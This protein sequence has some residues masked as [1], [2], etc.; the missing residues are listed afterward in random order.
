MTGN[1][2]CNVRQSRSMRPFACGATRV[3]ALFPSRTTRAAT[4]CA[5]HERLQAAP[6]RRACPC[7]SG[8]RK[9]WPSGRSIRKRAS[10]SALRCALAWRS[11]RRST[12]FRRGKART[13]L[14]LVPVDEASR[15]FLLV[16]LYKAADVLARVA[17]PQSD[18]RLLMLASKE[19]L[20]I[21][22]QMLPI[23]RHAHVFGRKRGKI[24]EKR[25]A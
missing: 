11:S 21:F 2:P 1:R 7:P 13:W 8:L 9:R 18:L 17:R 22:L 16:A 15:A 23:V 25:G 6:A 3:S 5:F 19:A 12:R 10:R 24:E 20:Q 4:G 14:A